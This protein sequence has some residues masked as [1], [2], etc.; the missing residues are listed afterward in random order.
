MVWL[1]GGGNHSLSG[2]GSPGFGGV[3]YNGKQLVPQGVVFVS[4]NL[5]LGA[6]GFLAHPAL[7]AERPEKISGNYGSLDQIAMLQWINHNIAA[8]GGDPSRV[9]LFGT[10]AGGG[11]ICAL[12]TSPLTRGLIHGVAMQSS[13]PAGCEFQTLGDA[14]SGT[15]QRVVSVLGCDAS[16]DVAACLR[17]KSVTEVVSTIP[18][19]FSVLT[20]I[21]G[22]NVDGHIFPDQPIKLIAQGRY[23]AMPIIIGNN[24]QETLV[25]ADTAGKVTDEASYAAAIDKV[26]GAAARD[27][28]L[29]LYPA[30]AYPSPR[31][32][33]AQVTTDAEFTCQSRRVAR[34]ISKVQREPVYRYLFNHVM[35]NDPEVKAL[36]ATHTGEHPFLFAWQ[37]PTGQ[38]MPIAPCSG[39]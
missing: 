25:W 7:D 24:G 31:I 29:R 17:S 33:F 13:V 3:V 37:V 34:V 18:G 28:I 16:S 30:R 36:G 1:T 23:P 15:G 5:R 19:N 14:E 8:F 21:Y 39:K 4:Y 27:R 12:M 11:N 20:R 35:E 2:Q 6:L 22:T 26:F 10:S 38:P 9:F 32:A